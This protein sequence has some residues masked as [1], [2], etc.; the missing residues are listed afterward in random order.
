MP[1]P[2]ER[3]TRLEEI[4]QDI[5]LYLYLWR[6][7]NSTLKQIEEELDIK[8]TTIRGLVERRV[9]HGF[10][11]KK[12]VRP[13]IMGEKKFTFSLSKI[14]VDFLKKIYTMLKDQNFQF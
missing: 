7:P 14:T 10:I 5:S 12:S 4:L 9:K 8:Y 1:K 2:I 3:K 6:N 11:I 13:I